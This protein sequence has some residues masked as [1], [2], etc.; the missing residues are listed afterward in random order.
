M[1]L[2][3]KKGMLYLIGGKEDRYYEKKV[4]TKMV[5]LTKASHITLIPT[6]SSYPLDMAREYTNA[7]LDLGV[8]DIDV[9][10]IRYKKDVDTD[11]NKEIIKKTD[12]VFF[13]GGDQVRL[14]E[15]MLGTELLKLIKDRHS[16]GLHVAGSSAGAHIASSPMLYYGE[17]R[18]LIKGSVESCNGFGFLPNITIDTHFSNRKRIYR[19]TQFLLSSKSDMGIGLAENT[20]IAI[21]ND[22]IFEVIGSGFITILKKSQDYETNYDEVSQKDKISVDGLSLSFLNSGMKY[23]L[24]RFKLLKI[25]KLA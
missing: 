19:L 4:L 9:L 7:F 23:D 22:N 11:E 2:N 25:K 1:D 12:V 8:E 14:S 13:T 16:N 5:E 24:N 21:F 15:I 10:D 3:S 6:A 20:A 17:R 18:G